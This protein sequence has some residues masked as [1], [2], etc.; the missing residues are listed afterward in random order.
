LEI[1]SRDKEIVEAVKA[2]FRT[3]RGN[4]GIVIKDIND[5]ATRFSTNIMA[6]ELLRKCR[7][8][9]APT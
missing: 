1:K 9:G 2:Q 5:P 4:K 8:E 3:D 6:Y 7:K